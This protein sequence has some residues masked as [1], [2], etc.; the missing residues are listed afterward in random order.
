MKNAGAALLSSQFIADRHQTHAATAERQEPDEQGRQREQREDEQRKP[1]G[2]RLIYSEQRQSEDGEKLIR[3]DVGRGV[4]KR[5]AQVHDHIDRYPDPD[6]EPQPV[7]Q[8]D[9][10]EGERLQGEK[11]QREGDRQIKLLRAARLAQSC[12]Q[13][14][15]QRDYRAQRLPFEQAAVRRSPALPLPRPWPAKDEVGEQRDE[16]RDDG[17][18][19]LAGFD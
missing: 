18:E 14:R 13:S 5:R 17:A 3:T 11:K 2:R 8:H 12:S 9:Q 6:G 1:G 15:E 16:Q 10:P 4:R 7:A 19:R